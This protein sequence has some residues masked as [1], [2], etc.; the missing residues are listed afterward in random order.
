MQRSFYDTHDITQPIVYG[1]VAEGSAVPVYI[2]MTKNATRR[3]DNYRNI[4]RCKN[5]RLARWL[6]NNNAGFVV[7]YEGPDYRGH[8]A[9]LIKESADELFN[10]VRG[11][12]QNWRTHRRKPWMAKTGVRCPS[13]AAIRIIGNDS[14][15]PDYKAWRASLSDAERCSHEVIVAREMSWHVGFM[16]VFEKWVEFAGAAVF[17]TLSA[18]RISPLTKGR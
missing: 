12:D 2:G 5:I 3:M 6:E 1:I 18:G 17:E 7:L 4:Q 9:E 13:D 10:F 16:Q 11:G 8:E 14:R 15:T